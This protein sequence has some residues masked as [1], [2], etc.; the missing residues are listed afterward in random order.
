MKG[1]KIAVS[2]R[3]AIFRMR[4]ASPAHILRLAIVSESFINNYNRNHSDDRGR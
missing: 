4:L 1:P 3:L 2:S